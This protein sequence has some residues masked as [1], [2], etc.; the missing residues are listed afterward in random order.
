[1]GTEPGEAAIRSGNK[2]QSIQS[3]ENE[4]H[5]QEKETIGVTAFFSELDEPLVDSSWR[6]GKH[7]V[8]QPIRRRVSMRTTPGTPPW[9]WMSQRRS[10]DAS[11]IAAIN[12]GV[13]IF[14]KNE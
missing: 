10:A 14:R 12:D 9:N 1:M 6:I 3:G 13:E 4:V 5:S 11:V 2:E 7:H 8:G